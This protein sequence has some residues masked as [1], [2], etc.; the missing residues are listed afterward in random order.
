[1]RT[2]FNALSDEEKK[3]AI[4]MRNKTIYTA[5]NFDG[6]FALATAGSSGAQIQTLSISAAAYYAINFS[7]TNFNYTSHHNEIATV[8]MSLYA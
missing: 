8:S 1:M 3:N 6:V 7:G 2:A 5:T 4:L